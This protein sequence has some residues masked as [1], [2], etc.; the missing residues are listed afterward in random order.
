MDIRIRDGEDIVITAIDGKGVER[1]MHIS[2]AK[3]MFAGS[4]IIDGLS[5]AEIKAIDE[6]RK[7]LAIK[8]YRQRNNASLTDAKTFIEDWISRN[9]CCIKYPY[10]E[11]NNPNDG[12]SIDHLKTMPIG[13]LALS[14]YYPA[15]ITE[16]QAKQ[17]MSRC[18]YDYKNYGFYSFQQKS[19][20]TTWMSNALTHSD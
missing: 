9:R 1:Q 19:S 14:W 5:S 6:R 15:V 10:C 4:E 13:P 7:I 2:W 17:L 16:S 3:V 20:E 8:Y 11:H 12:L 18:K